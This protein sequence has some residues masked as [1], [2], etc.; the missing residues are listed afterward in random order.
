MIKFL[1]RRAICA[2]LVVM[3]L[4]ASAL[5][6]EPAGTGLGQAWPNAQDVSASSHWHVY[7]FTTNGVRYIQIN[8]LNGNV[9]GAFA[10]ANGQ[11]LVLPMGRDAQRISTPQ[12]PVSTSDTVAPLTSYAETV[13]RDASVQLNAV[14]LSDGTTMFMAAPSTTSTTAVSPC[15]NPVECNGHIVSQ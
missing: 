12:Q 10:T 5:A 8:D 13:Y 1:P 14:P 3:G 4:S 9:R 15:D 2:G 6:A 7:V 11:Y